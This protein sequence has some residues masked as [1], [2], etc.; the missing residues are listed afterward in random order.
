M[1]HVIIKSLDERFG[2]V[3]GILADYMLLGR[4]AV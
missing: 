2:P 4:D 1:S 3:G